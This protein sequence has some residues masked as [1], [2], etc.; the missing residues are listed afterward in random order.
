MDPLYMCTSSLEQGTYFILWFKKYAT[1]IAHT[2]CQG[3]RIYIFQTDKSA[4]VVQSVP[5][6][7]IRLELL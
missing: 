4:V 2:V 1:R 6:C 5:T 7:E 3:S